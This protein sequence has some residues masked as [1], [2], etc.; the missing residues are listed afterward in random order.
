MTSSK[1]MNPHLIT[2]ALDAVACDQWEVDYI[3]TSSYPSINPANDSRPYVYVQFDQTV[4]M[5]CLF[6]T[7]AQVCVMSEEVFNRSLNKDNNMTLTEPTSLTV[8]KRN[9]NKE[10]VTMTARTCLVRISVLGAVAQEFPLRISPDLSS[11]TGCIIGIDLIHKLKLSYD[12]ERQKVVAPGHK[13]LQPIQAITIA[14]NSTELVPFK[15]IEQCS[16]TYEIQSTSVVFDSC[17]TEKFFISPVLNDADDKT[18]VAMVTNCSSEDVTLRTDSEYGRGRLVN[19]AKVFPVER[20]GVDGDVY[21]RLDDYQRKPLTKEKRSYIEEH[22]KLGPTLSPAQK[23]K[24]KDIM[25]NHHEAFGGHPYDIGVTTTYVH[26]IK[27]KDETPLY[28]KQFRLAQTHKEW[29]VN[30]VKKLVEVGVLRRSV[31]KHNSAV[32]CVPKSSGALRMVLDLRPLNK[33]LEPFYY[34]SQPLEEIIDTVGQMKGR[35]FSV[36]DTLKGFWGLKLTERSKP[37]TAFTVHGQGKFE[38]NSCPQ[39][40]LSAPAGYSH[41]MSIVLTNLRHSMTYIDDI[42]TV[43]ANFDDHLKHVEALLCRLAKHDLRLNIEKCQFGFDEVTYLGF[44]IN[45]LGVRPGKSKTECIDKCEPP[46][47]KRQILAWVGLCNYFRKHVSKFQAHASKLTDLTKKNHPWQGGDL[48]EEALQAFYTMKKILTSR[49]ILRFPDYSREFLLST[50]ASTG[51]LGADGKNVGG[52]LGAALTQK[53]ESGEEYVI[54]YAS[55]SLKPHERNYAPFLL[56]MAG[57]CFGLEAFDV[58]LRGRKFTMFSDHRPIVNL[59]LKPIHRRTLNRLDEMMNQYDFTLEFRSG[60]SNVLADFAS[61]SLAV[62]AIAKIAEGPPANITQD[63]EKFFHVFGYN[64]QEMKVMQQCDPM[65]RAIIGAIKGENLTKEEK[66]D[67]RMAR[68]VAGL[69]RR[70]F[71]SADGVLFYRPLDKKHTPAKVL[72]FAPKPIHQEVIRMAHSNPVM[73]AHCGLTVCQD[74]VLT[75]YY[76]ATVLQD[77]AKFVQSCLICQESKGH[78]SRSRHRPPGPIH[79]HGQAHAPASIVHL[80]LV[81]PLPGDEKYKYVLS[82]TCAYSKFCRLAGVKSKQAEEI[83]TAFFDNWLCSFGSPEVIHVDG[84]KEFC[85]AFLSTL[86]TSMGIEGRISLPYRPQIQGQIE[87]FHRSVNRYLRSFLSSKTTN[88]SHY[89]RPIEF[90]HNTSRHRATLATPHSL[91]YTFTPRYAN[92]DSDGIRTMF[93]SN[94]EALAYR[95]RIAE[96]QRHA[97]ENNRIFREV[98]LEKFNS[99]RS[100]QQFTEGQLVMLHSPLQALRKARR[101]K[102]DSELRYKLA[103]PWVGPAVI[104]RVWP[105]SPGTLIE[106]CPSSGVKGKYKVHPDRLKEYHLAEGE[107]HPVQHPVKHKQWKQAQLGEGQLEGKKGRGRQA[108]PRLELGP[109]PMRLRPRAGVPQEYEE[110]EIQQTKTAGEVESDDDYVM[111]EDDVLTEGDD[112]LGDDAEDHGEGRDLVNVLPEE[113]PGADGEGTPALLD[114]DPVIEKEGSETE[115]KSPH[116][117]QRQQQITYNCELPQQRENSNLPHGDESVERNSHNRTE[118]AQSTQRFTAPP[119]DRPPMIQR[120]RGLGRRLLPFRWRNKGNATA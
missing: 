120:L 58:Y 98:Y 119:A 43:S 113:S 2:M 48:P 81:G 56:E 67:D 99:G 95:E 46:R 88:W 115:T 62:D 35:Y 105:S 112:E 84:G 28:Q 25:L 94:D 110:E 33:N 80:D 82:M 21:E 9:G 102:D 8:A 85:N 100:E 12:A 74:K 55:R 40:L 10:A 111:E 53:D 69:R 16:A 37:L 24:L 36:T 89:L 32:F 71:L 18:A 109:H 14:P 92:Y 22:L 19:K 101:E 70:C 66:A 116:H 97:Q 63:E 96:A 104:L 72:L 64:L 87:N 78:G 76:W 93:S 108:R 57:C 34:V 7:G 45:R 26:D 51:V 54:G 39:G 30:H 114:N 41:L 52:G 3:Q 47:T 31:S 77:V 117:I 6:D 50:D 60:S 4:H 29:L 90:A 91:M 103:R 73:G 75:S 20:L 59:F 42:I 49:P 68:T 61:R 106:F 27:V 5:P 79:T 107:P 65:T 38:Y 13:S 11:K 83:A 86:L 15:V 1:T 17:P 44:E 23:A 118:Q